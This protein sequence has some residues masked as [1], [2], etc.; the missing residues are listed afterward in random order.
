MLTDTYIIGHYNPLSQDYDLASHTTHVVCV[1][2]IHELNADFEKLFMGIF[3]LRVFVRYLLGGSRQRNIFMALSA[4][5]LLL[6][7]IN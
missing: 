6:S 2:L 4:N 1:N 7:K 5:T 3:P